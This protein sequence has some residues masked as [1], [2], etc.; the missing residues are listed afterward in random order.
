[1]MFTFLFCNLL[2]RVCE[3]I[4]ESAFDR[5]KCSVYIWYTSIWSPSNLQAGA[6]FIIEIGC[7]SKVLERFK[8]DR[9]IVK[10][11]LAWCPKPDPHDAAALY[12]INR[13]SKKSFLMQVTLTSTILRR[14]LL[15]H[16]L[17]GSYSDWDDSQYTHYN[18]ENHGYFNPWCL[19]FLFAEIN[20]TLD[21]FVNVLFCWMTWQR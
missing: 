21:M 10:T 20:C 15:G 1:M 17:T 18:R 7:T 3:S 13:H 16:S 12:T 11:G 2:N 19:D 9:I 6:A 5:N 4:Q 8:N 14:D